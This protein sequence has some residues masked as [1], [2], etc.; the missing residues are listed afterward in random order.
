MLV[1]LALRGCHI[2]TVIKIT[3]GG[4]YGKTI[5]FLPLESF[6]VRCAL[7]VSDC[8]IRKSGGCQ[9]LACTHILG[10][11]HRR[12]RVNIHL[13]D[14][15][16][17]RRA[18]HC[19]KT[20]KIPV[21]PQQSGETPSVAATCVLC[22]VGKTRWTSDGTRQTTNPAIPMVN[23]TDLLGRNRIPHLWR[24]FRSQPLERDHSGPAS[25]SG[26]RPHQDCDF[27]TKTTPTKK[28][29]IR[30]RTDIVPKTTHL[31]ASQSQLSSVGRC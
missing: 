8:G 28:L 13:L 29:S 22:V 31:F 30:G 16:T 4:V 2:D 3:G 25:G 12:F 6:G 18:R 9:A 1:S 15:I 10:N 19:D 20:T 14:A 11:D 26:C 27:A 17:A 5:S 23:P 24:C 21:E 7:Y